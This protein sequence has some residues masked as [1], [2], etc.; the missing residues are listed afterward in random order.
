VVTIL[1][2]INIVGADFHDGN[3]MASNPTLSQL[4]QCSIIL[5]GRVQLAALN[6]SLD[7][8]DATPSARASKV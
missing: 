7:K 3:R 1:N 2:F 4:S 6:A 5:P 8:T